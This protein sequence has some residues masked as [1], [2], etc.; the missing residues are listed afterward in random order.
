MESHYDT[1]HYDS[2]HQHQRNYQQN[3]QATSRHANVPALSYQLFH[4][5]ISTKFI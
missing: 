5:P 1:K 2:S 4:F 3:H